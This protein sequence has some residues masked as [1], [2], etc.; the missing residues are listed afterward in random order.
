MPSIRWQHVF[1]SPIATAKIIF[2][3]ILS[4]N[5]AIARHLFASPP[6][7]LRAEIVRLWYGTA[8]AYNSDIFYSEPAGH[9]TQSFVVDGVL[10]YAIPSIEFGGLQKADAVYIHA[11]GGGFAI[12]HPLQYLEEYKRWVANAARHGKRLVILAPVYRMFILHSSHLPN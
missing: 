3:S 12:G 4:S 8:L 10:T 7:S 1:N 6:L 5:A 11:H 9:D 2:F